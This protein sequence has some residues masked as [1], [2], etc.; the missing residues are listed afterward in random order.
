MKSKEAYELAALYLSNELYNRPL[1]DDTIDGV[2]ISG[3]D[4]T[5]ALWEAVRHLE[6][7]AEKANSRARVAS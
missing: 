3:H 7:L 6:S 1:Q 2:R 5:G 4:I